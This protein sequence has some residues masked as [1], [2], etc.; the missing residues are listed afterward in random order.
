MIIQVKTNELIEARIRSG[1]SQ[2][3][4]SR[5]TGISHVTIS[6]IENGDRRPS[7]AT[8][9]K[10]CEALNV[11]FNDIFFTQGVHKSKRSERKEGHY[12]TS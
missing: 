1:F 4:L 6:Q 3:G 2:R 8:A 11:S 9:K 5:K 10:I 12:E 7:P